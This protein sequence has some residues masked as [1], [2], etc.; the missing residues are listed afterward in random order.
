MIALQRRMNDKKKKKKTRNINALLLSYLSQNITTMRRGK[1]ASSSHNSA[2]NT[3]TATQAEAP[4]E[5]VVFKSKDGTE[6]TKSKLIAM[7][8]AEFK[9]LIS[10]QDTCK[11]YVEEKFSKVLYTSEGDQVC[12]YTFF[13]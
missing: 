13:K 12:L 5:L 2:T 6:Y 11:F 3:T 1:K 9:T 7:P 10:R 4:K 8:F